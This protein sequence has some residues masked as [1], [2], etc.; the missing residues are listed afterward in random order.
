[1]FDVQL[2]TTHLVPNICFVQRIFYVQHTHSISAMIF[3]ITKG[4]LWSAIMLL[5]LWTYYD[6]KILLIAQICSATSNFVQRVGS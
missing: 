3:E 6:K 5:H 2:S 1:M 4:S